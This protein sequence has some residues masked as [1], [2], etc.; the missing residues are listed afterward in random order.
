M[1]ACE[2]EEYGAADAGSTEHVDTKVFGNA[3]DLELATFSGVADTTEGVVRKV[4]GNTDDL[5]HAKISGETTAS[6]RTS[7]GRSSG[8]PTTWSARR[9]RGRGFPEPASEHRRAL[10]R[11]Q[12]ERVRRGSDAGRGGTSLSESI[13]ICPARHRQGRAGALAY[14]TLRW[15]RTPGFRGWSPTSSRPRRPGISEIISRP[16]GICATPP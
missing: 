15:Q 1:G 13:R 12:V 7:S 10:E 5:D 11:L 16:S 4:L 6:R 2:D 14:G 8:T 9:P 3:D